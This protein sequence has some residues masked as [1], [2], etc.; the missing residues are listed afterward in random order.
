MQSLRISTGPS[1]LWSASRP[2]VVTLLKQKLETEKNFPGAGLLPDYPAGMYWPL[3]MHEHAG[4]LWIGGRP[5]RRHG[6]SGLFRL[7]LAT[8]K[9]HRY[10]P[11][12]GFRYDDHNSYTSYA[13][14]WAGDAMWVATSFGLVEVT[15]RGK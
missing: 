12:D 3:F 10:G 13:G 5:W 11:R 4:S 6:D 8:G 2:N 9:L 14:V 1:G 15:L 7:D